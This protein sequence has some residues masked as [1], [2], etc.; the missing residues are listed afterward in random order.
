MNLVSNSTLVLTEPRTLEAWDVIIPPAKKPL[1]TI[2]KIQ[3]GMEGKVFTFWQA[4]SNGEALGTYHLANGQNIVAEYF[5]KANEFRLAYKK[6]LTNRPGPTTIEGRG[7][8]AWL[9]SEDG[10]NISLESNFCVDVTK[11]P[12][13]RLFVHKSLI[14]PSIIHY[15]ENGSY[16]KQVMGDQVPVLEDKVE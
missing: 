2:A 11:L 7:K 8:Q 4:W 9:T 5:I 15:I 10:F 1:L 13:C 12:K 16:T 6:A 14:E 3:S